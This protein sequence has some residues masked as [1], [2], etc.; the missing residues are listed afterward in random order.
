MVRK[1]P[2]L[3]PRTEDGFIDYKSIFQTI[4]T[5]LKQPY[6]T[7]DDLTVQEVSWLL[8]G[9]LEN[10]KDHY[11]MISYAMKVAGASIMSGKDIRL[12][13]EESQEES[14]EKDDEELTQREKRE[15]DLVYLEDT[16]GEL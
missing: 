10:K 13:E 4:Y 8:Q 5:D 3:L 16:F 2:F 6:G 15:Q 7:L 1:T 9:N 14:I 11:E 12:F